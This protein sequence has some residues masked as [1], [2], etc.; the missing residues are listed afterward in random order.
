[1]TAAATTTPPASPGFVD[2][3]ASEWLKLRSL[4]L[5]PLL[6][7]AIVI[8]SVAVGAFMSII[9]GDSVAEAQAENEYSVIFYSSALTTWAFAG[10][11]A[12][13]VGI[14]FSGV[15]QTTFTATARRT[16]VLA[17]KV[18]LIGV[19]GAL[20][21][22]LSS[23]ATA[24]ATQ[25]VL[26][27]RGFEPL[28]L[29]D[30]GLLRAVLILVGASM[31]VQGLIAA[32]FAVLTAP[33]SGDWSRPGW[34]RS[35]RELRESAGRVV[36]RAHPAMAARGGGGEPRWRCRTRGVRVP[37]RPLALTTVIAWLAVVLTI[38]TLRLRRLDIA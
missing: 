19:A 20:T 29:T 31:A 6:L 25:G 37:A 12:N 16:R 34:S 1:V 17:A 22:V 11:A 38:A 3:L 33:P 18:V 14:E 5:Y 9:G 28:D 26:V 30:P 23:V 24:A 27:L 4:R 32:G 7:A 13:F 10:I 15:G 8:V 21:G 36:L 2:T 35:C